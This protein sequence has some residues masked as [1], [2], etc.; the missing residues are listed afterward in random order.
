MKHHPLSNKHSKT[1]TQTPLFAHAS[2]LLPVSFSLNT[3]SSFSAS[4][5]QSPPSFHSGFHPS[6]PLLSSL[7]I[8]CTLRTH[9]LLQ[10]Q[11]PVRSPGWPTSTHSTRPTSPSGLK[12]ADSSLMYFSSFFSSSELFLRVNSR[13]QCDTHLPPPSSMMMSMHSIIQKN[14]PPLILRSR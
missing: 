12:M 9:H 13:R 10:L 5:S 1:W 3:N 7:H 14:K 4:I 8:T 11:A 6:T 2:A